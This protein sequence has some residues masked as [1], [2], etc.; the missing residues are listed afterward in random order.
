ML[1]I[2]I[3]GAGAVGSQM[4]HM[5]AREG[6]T[7]Y[8][9]DDDNI[10]TQNLAVSV[11]RNKDIARQKADSLAE[12]ARER[13]AIA[14]PINA[15]LT[16]SEQLEELDV[17]LVIDGFDNTDARA[18]TVGLSHPTLHVGV[19]TQGNGIA[20]WDEDYT[21]PPKTF[22]RGSNPVCTNALG[23]KLIRRTALVGVEAVEHYVASQGEKLSA[24]VS[25]NGEI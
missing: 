21:L 17:D 6:V 11:Y 4:V 23:K 18:L 25:E 3:A 2:A 1:R 16:S 20:F 5:L 22:E 7:F 24:V 13:G 10:E 19:G 8:I 9:L 12:I 15:T 14:I